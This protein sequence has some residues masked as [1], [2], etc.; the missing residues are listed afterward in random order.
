[1]D[2]VDG[3]LFHKGE[4]GVQRLPMW[5]STQGVCVGMPDLMINNLTRSTFTFPAT[6]QGAA[7]FMPTVNRFIATANL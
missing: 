3:A 4:A 5:L 1:M 6:G 2:Y 7:L